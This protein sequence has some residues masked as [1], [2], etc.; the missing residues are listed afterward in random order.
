MSTR[1][2]T[3]F[4]LEDINELPYRDLEKLHK[5]KME[6]KSLVSALEHE[7]SPKHLSSSSVQDLR[8]LAEKVE[9]VSLEYESEIEKEVQ[10]EIEGFFAGLK[11][12]K[13]IIKQDLSQR[14]SGLIN[15]YS[16]LRRRL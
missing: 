12:L 14:F 9:T 6:K 5:L 8:K 13:R 16:I 15:L 3:E 7:F 10:E 4:S 2:L 11:N 1:L